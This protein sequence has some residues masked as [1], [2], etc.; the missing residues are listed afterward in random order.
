[1]YKYGMR[2]RGYAPKCQPMDGLTEWHETPDGK[3]YG[4]LTYNR[5]LSEEEV[6]DYELD[7]LEGE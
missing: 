2:L 1:M 4:I 7:E 3:Y 6:R 5:R